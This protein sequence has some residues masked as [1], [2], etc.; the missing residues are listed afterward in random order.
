M[1]QNEI[2]V[3]RAAR[4]A[5]V[6][7]RKAHGTLLAFYVFAAVLNGEAL[8]REAELLPYGPGRDLAIR[9]ARPL[10]WS[11]RITQLG[12]LRTGAESMAPSH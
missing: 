10:A 5:G 11:A 12:R 8:L 1:K 4:S 9:L 3:D 7:R 6:L 2:E